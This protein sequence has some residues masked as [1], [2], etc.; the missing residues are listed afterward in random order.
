MLKTI[1]AFL[2]SRLEKFSHWTQRLAG[3]TCVRW[4]ALSA[5][6]LAGF[7]ICACVIS[8]DQIP[9]LLFTFILCFV[10]TVGVERREDAA[11]E[12]VAKGFANPKRNMW[13]GRSVLVAG[14]VL[15]SVFSWNVHG[16]ESLR[17]AIE[18]LRTITTGYC[19][20][21]VLEYFDA[22]DPLPRGE[23]KVRLWLNSFKHSLRAVSVN[24]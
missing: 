6:V 20:A 4:A 23:S 21:P 12:R 3:I 15:L 9:G 7:A 19:F 18:A 14:A 8:H 13:L 5:Y 24:S 22:C 17:R 10:K 2:V 16:G 11:S 1:D